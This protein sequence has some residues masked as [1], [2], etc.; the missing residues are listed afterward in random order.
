[1]DKGIENMSQINKCV[2]FLTHKSCHEAHALG[3]IWQQVVESIH[4]F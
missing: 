1:M 3:N 2:F 4:G